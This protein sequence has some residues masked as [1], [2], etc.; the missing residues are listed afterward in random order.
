MIWKRFEICERRKREFFSLKPKKNSQFLLRISRF[1]NIY[2]SLSGVDDTLLQFFP[3]LV[4]QIRLGSKNKIIIR[5]CKFFFL[6]IQRREKQQYLNFL[7]SFFSPFFHILIFWRMNGCCWLGFCL[8]VYISNFRRCC[9]C[10]A[11]VYSL[12]FFHSKRK[13]KVRKRE[14]T[15]NVFSFRSV[16]KKEK[17]QH[18]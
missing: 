15:V 16:S 8:L 18:F 2:Y 12:S 3:L 1:S 13:G 10:F 17:H 4:S 5:F 6:Q 7:H 9:S 11:L 14:F